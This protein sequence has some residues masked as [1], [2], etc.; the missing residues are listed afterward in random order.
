MKMSGQNGVTCML[1]GQARQTPAG[2]LVAC[3]A[4]DRSHT[5]WL[6]RPNEGCLNACRAGPWPTPPSATTTGPWTGSASGS[7]AS[8]RTTWLAG[9]TTS[10][11]CMWWIWRASGKPS[12]ALEPR[13]E[14]CRHAKH[15]HNPAAGG[16]AQ[17]GLTDPPGPVADSP[18]GHSS[19]PGAILASSGAWHAGSICTALQQGAMMGLISP[20][21]S[22][23]MAEIR[24]Q[25]DPPHAQ[26][27][28]LDVAGSKR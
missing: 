18:H 23:S 5:S 27:L 24:E 13:A 8:G 9:P 3:R 4:M 28:L 2:S 17:P 10:P 12:V 19:T 22:R 15:L 6:G 16:R 7:K 26:A 11:P 20:G 21:L 14:S 1:A 25:P